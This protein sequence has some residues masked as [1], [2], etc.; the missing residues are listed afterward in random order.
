MRFPPPKPA[1]K[2]HLP[3]YKA[4]QKCQKSPQ[5]NKHAYLGVRGGKGKR[6][7]DNHPAS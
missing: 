2:V 5:C 1:L 7:Y 4:V 6:G 3:T